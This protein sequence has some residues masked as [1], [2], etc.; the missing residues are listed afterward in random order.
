MARYNQPEN[1]DLTKM[2]QDL[3]DQLERL[4]RV[5]A[6]LHGI[7]AGGTTGQVLEKVSGADYDV[8]WSTDN[9]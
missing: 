2:V 6:R 8:A 7:P 1:T 9:T 4:E 3:R 5:V